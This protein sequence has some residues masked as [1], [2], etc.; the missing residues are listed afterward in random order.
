M[1][2]A[3]ARIARS[4]GP[5]LSCAFLQS[6]D[7]PLVSLPLD[8]LKAKLDR[9]GID[10]ASEIT[11]LSKIRAAHAI[12]CLKSDEYPLSYLHDFA[13]RRFAL[14]DEAST[15]QR[16]YHKSETVKILSSVLSRGEL[17]PLLMNLRQGHEEIIEP[18]CAFHCSSQL[19]IDSYL[20][21][22]A[23]QRCILSP[24]P[25]QICISATNEAVDVCTLAEP[26]SAEVILCHPQDLKSVRVV[27]PEPL[28]H[29]AVLEVTKNALQ[30]TKSSL[31]SGNV[32]PV[33][34]NLTIDGACIVI[35]VRDYGRGVEIHDEKSMWKFGWST[36]SRPTLLAGSGIGL[37]LSKIY[38]ELYGG[39]IH[40]SRAETGCKFTL[41]VPL[42]SKENLPSFM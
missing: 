3:A 29:Y 1:E 12:L 41:S 11:R 6:L 17:L 7:E 36:T 14:L 27:F 40:H 42:T 20:Q 34:L 18:F 24:V 2:L 35:E 10:A 22:V 16:G 25:L 28:L 33:H 13:V 30:S 38:L 26:S 5:A 9:Q 31:V 39:S 32:Y 19:L 37:A 21:S 23:A 8:S 15:R 4:F